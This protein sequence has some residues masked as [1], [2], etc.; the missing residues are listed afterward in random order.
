VGL[1]SVDAVSVIDTAS[2]V[3]TTTIPVGDGPE[4]L[5]VTPDGS[6][7]YVNN[8]LSDTISIVDTVTN[9]V[10][11]T[12]PVL[13][14]GPMSYGD[15]ITTGS[16]ASTT[17]TSTSSTTSTSATSTTLPAF[18]AATLDCQKAIGKS[19]KR[20]G[21]KA[22]TFIG[23]CLDKILS[24]L[25]AGGQP[26]DALP[27]CR[28]AIDLG[29]TTSRLSRARVAVRG[30]ILDRCVGATLASLENAC[31]PSAATMA[32]VADCVLDEQLLAAMRAATAEY[33]SACSL[34]EAVGL[35]QFPPACPAP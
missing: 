35:A 16:P 17:T 10:I 28:T 20:Y 18:N 9:G 22:H 12:V 14:E 15:F 29:Q 25:S 21:A 8:V 23:G 24:V 1:F 7:L 31:S 26:S 30:T 11:A 32:E 5:D 2:E 33:G 3:Q 4:G 13:G 6:R 27:S 19:F 34:L